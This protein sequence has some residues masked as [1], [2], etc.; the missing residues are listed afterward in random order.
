MPLYFQ[1]SK[2]LPNLTYCCRFSP[3]SVQ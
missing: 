1:L 3:P 2:T